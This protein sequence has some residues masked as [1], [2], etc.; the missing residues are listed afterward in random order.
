MASITVPVL[1]ITNVNATT[2]S[3]RV[4]YTLTPSLIERLA[5]TVFQDTIIAI[6]DDAPFGSFGGTD[7]IVSI[8]PTAPFAVNSATINVPRTITVNRLKS[9]LNEDPTFLA[10]GAEQMDEIFARV[11]IAY[12]AAAPAVPTLPVPTA[13][14]QVSGAW[15]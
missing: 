6:G 7:I 12:A 9:S 5:G 10:T 14:N 11:T 3:L 1:T 8:F 13:S 4:T 15:K 2:V